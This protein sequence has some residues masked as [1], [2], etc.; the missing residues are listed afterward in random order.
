MN[1]LE[2]FIEWFKEYYLHEYKEL[3]TEFKNK[4]IEDVIENNGDYISKDFVLDNSDMCDQC[5]LCCLSQFQ[6]CEYF[7]SVT[8]LC[9]AHDDQPWEIC[10]LYPYGPL[11]LIGPLTINCMYQ[12]RLFIKFLNEVFTEEIDKE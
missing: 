3:S 2:I 10:K 11:G 4:I 1:S 5:G 7:N 6:N 9:E 12:V 8:H